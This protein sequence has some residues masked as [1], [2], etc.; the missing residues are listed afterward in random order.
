MDDQNIEMIGMKLANRA[1][2]YRVFHIVFGAE[3]SSE[4]IGILS[5]ALTL[6]AFRYLRDADATAANFEH[7]LELLDSLD[8]KATDE[9]FIDGLRSDY[10][11]L[12]QVPGPNY[13]YIWESPYIGKQKTIFQ[14]STLDVRYRFREYGFEAEEAGH[15]PEDHLSMMLDFLAHLSTRAFDAFGDGDDN[16]A[17]RIVASQ[18]NFVE[19]HLMNWFHLFLD[20]L[21]KKDEAGMYYQLAEALY[22]FLRIDALFAEEFLAR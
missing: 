3:P 16:E 15:F 8:D 21:E 20:D 17:T 22:G 6:D 18:K 2:L 7:T 5:D 9:S 12:L 14:E 1:Y 13:V 19:T 4:E 10:I 11:R